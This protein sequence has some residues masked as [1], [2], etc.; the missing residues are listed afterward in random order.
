M[1]IIIIQR[2]WKKLVSDPQAAGDNR[3]ITALRALL[4]DVM[5]R[6]YVISIFCFIVYIFL[7]LSYLGHM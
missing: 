5:L 6:R 2:W 7:I 3:G 4:T 1:Y